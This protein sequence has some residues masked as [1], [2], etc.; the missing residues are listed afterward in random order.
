MKI[1]T[2]LF[3]GPVP[4]MTMRFSPVGAVR[5]VNFS[6]FRTSGFDVPAVFG[7]S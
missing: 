4:L 6:S 2:K 7:S 5:F 1:V 3:G